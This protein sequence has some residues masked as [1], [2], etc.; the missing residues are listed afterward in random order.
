MVL[1]SVIVPARDARERLPSCL[2]GLAGEGVPSAA[3]ELIVVDDASI[4]GTAEVAAR[5]D[6]RVLKGAGR[7]PAAARNLG[8]RHARGEIL[9]FLD[10]DAVPEA[11]WLEGMLAPLRHDASVVAVKGR[12][13]SN[14]PG[15]MARF[16]QL[17]FEEKYARLERAPRVDFVDSGTCAFRRDAF[18]AV[19]GFDESFP[20]QSAEDVELAFRLAAHGARFA[21]NAKAGVFHHHADRLWQY[22]VK[23]ARYGYFR[24]AV[25]RRYPNKTLGDSYTPPSMGLQIGLAG[26]VGLVGMFA[27]IGAPLAGYALAAVLASFLVTTLPLVRRAGLRQPVLACLVPLLVFARAT[28]QGLGIAAA[29]VV[30]AAGTFRVQAGTPRGRAWRLEPLSHL[31]STG[32]GNGNVPLL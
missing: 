16:T 28:A 7:G 3:V 18:L 5:P 12:Y 30:G 32:N 31:D 9:V 6:V 15:L 14:Q 8:A 13:Y 10:A 23:K 29:L 24:I 1:V 19:G 22:L 20:A 4:D 17:E 21:F 26:T 11:G 2:D 27:A 25:Y